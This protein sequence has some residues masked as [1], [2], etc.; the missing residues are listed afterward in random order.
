V[1]PTPDW[2]AADAVHRKL[3]GAVEHKMRTPMDVT[4]GVPIEM[5]VRYK[6]LITITPTRTAVAIAVVEFPD[7][8]FDFVY[9]PT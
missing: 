2:V 4:E 9:R 7:G 1:T 5:R 3:L 8:T 6:Q